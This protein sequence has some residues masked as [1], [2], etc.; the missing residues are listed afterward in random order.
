MRTLYL[1]NLKEG[2]PGLSENY[3][4]FIAEAA[5]LCFESYGHQS[6]V[7]LEVLGDY[8]QTVSL[9]WTNVINQ[10]VKKSWKD[11]NEAV[12]YAATAVAILL[13]R[14]FTSFDLLERAIQT[15]KVDYWLENNL[16]NSSDYRFSDPKGLLE[17][18]GIGEETK[19]NTINMRISSKIK[20]VA[21]AKQYKFPIFIIVV[22]FSKPQ[23]KWIKA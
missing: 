5:A 13:V 2:I 15:M 18:S 11:A 21:P 22:E 10:R 8:E 20:Q 7:I 14:E 17:I 19:G 12:E 16:K 23:S 9:H 1:D 3:G 6:G 4:A